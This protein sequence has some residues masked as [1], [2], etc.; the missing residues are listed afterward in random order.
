MSKFQKT[1]LGVVAALG[2]SLPQSAHA[3]PLETVL[4][5]SIDESS[6]I[7]STNFNTQMNAYIA[8]A[9]IIPTDG[10]IAVGAHTFSTNVNDELSIFRL[11]APGD[12]TPLTDWFEA[13]KSDFDGGN[14]D[15]AESIDTARMD[16]NAFL[17]ALNLEC[18]ED[19]NC[20]IDVSTDGSQ[21]VSGNPVTEAAEAVT[22]GMIVNCL[23]IGDNANCDFA[24]E[25]SG[26][27]FPAANFDDIERALRQKIAVE[28]GQELPEPGAIAL[29]G[30]GLAGLGWAARRRKAS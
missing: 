18:D 15:I 23:G 12:L 22:Q 21:T 7:G 28:T 13:Q 19:V 20:I 1:L 25:N 8:A 9:S 11:N 4:F 27:A 6:S 5:F 16:I 14:T 3:V 2:L 26:L 30:L 24:T 17:A 10:S 29:M